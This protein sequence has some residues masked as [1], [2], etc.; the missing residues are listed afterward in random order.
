G[1]PRR[2]QDSTT[3]RI[4]ATFGPA[5]ALPT[6]NQFLRPGATGRIE[7]SPGYWTTPL[8]GS[9]NTA[10]ASPTYLMCRRPLVPA[11]FSATFAEPT[12]STPPKSPAT[13]PRRIPGDERDVHPS[14]MHVGAHRDRSETTRPCA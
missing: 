10:A 9:R 11:R 3:E 12:S 5:C 2:R 4:A 6:C 8:P 7:F 1:A 13:T 14:S